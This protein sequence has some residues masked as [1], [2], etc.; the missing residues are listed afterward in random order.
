LTS[1]PVVRRD[2]NLVPILLP[3]GPRNSSASI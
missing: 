3:V 2:A 1:D